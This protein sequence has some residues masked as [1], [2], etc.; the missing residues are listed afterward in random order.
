MPYQSAGLDKSIP[1]YQVIGNHDQYW[2]GTL[3]F[4][5]YVRSILVGNTVIDMGFDGDNAR[6]LHLMPVA[7]TWASLT[8][9]HRTG[10]S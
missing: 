5:D 6:S 2:C 7:S 1:W 10:P 3:S 8:G 9:R 4:D